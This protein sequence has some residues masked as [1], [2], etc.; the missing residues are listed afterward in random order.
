MDIDILWQKDIKVEY[1]LSMIEKK[2]VLYMLV[3]VQLAKSNIFHQQE[4][5]CKWRPLK[6]KRKEI[7]VLTSFGKSLPQI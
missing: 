4:S 6:K 2:N 3:Y 1:I 5:V 7:K